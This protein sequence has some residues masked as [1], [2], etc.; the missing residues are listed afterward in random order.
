MLIPSVLEHERTIAVLSAAASRKALFAWG[1]TGTDYTANLSVGWERRL[2]KIKTDLAETF[3]QAALAGSVSSG[4]ALADQD[5][6][7]APD[8]FVNVH[9]FTGYAASGV[10]LNDLLRRP[11]SYSKQLIGAGVPVQEAWR[12]GGIMLDGIM[13]TQVADVARQAASVDIATRVGIGYTRMVGPGACSR[14]TILAGKFF[15]WNQGF[16]RHPR[17]N[18]VHVATT[19]KSTAAAQAE[20]LI[21][22]PYEAFNALSREEQDRIYGAAN[23]AAIRDGS[24][25]YQVVNANRR[26]S[27]ITTAEGTGKR[28][29]SKDLKGKRL[30]PEGIYSQNLSREE[31]LKLLRENNYILPGGQLPGGSV[32]GQ[33]EGFGALGRGGSRV[34]ARS[35]VE[36]ARRTGIRNPTSRATMTEAERRLFDSRNRYEQVLSG[37]N[38]YGKSPLTPQLSAQAEAEYK[39]WLATGGQIFN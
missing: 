18:C 30:T 37:Q 32:R 4:F 6:W 3:R 38:P 25:I 13:K 15:R 29:Y 35:E 31:T 19:A 20:G 1:R 24:D 28:G 2:P 10:P 9:A 34:G 16:L 5:T 11:V 22:D 12:R 8:H 21:S 36:R 26:G 23:A 33:A 7:V 14:C 39:R 27:G 17:C